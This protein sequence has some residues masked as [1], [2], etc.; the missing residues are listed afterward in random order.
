[1]ALMHFNAGAR[2]GYI[3]KQL[4]CCLIVGVLSQ[5]LL[6]DINVLAC[7]PEWAALATALGKETVNV[8]SA[9]TYQQ[10]P[11]HIQARPSLIAKARKADL[12][13]CSGAGLEE[14]WL[15]LLTRK[16]NNSKIQPG[17]I[18]HFVATEYV[19]LLGGSKKVDRSEGD[20][21]GLGNPHIHMNPNNILKVAKALSNTLSELEPERKSYFAENLS[22]F[23]KDIQKMQAKWK[24]Q[25]GALQGQQV[26]VH[27]DSWAYLFQWLGLEKVA[28][29]EPKPGLP[30]STSH[31]SKLLIQVKDKPTY[32]II[33]SSY[34][35]SK[36]AIWLGK[37]S[38]TP[39]I[40]LPYT[41]NNW[42]KDDALVSYYESLIKALLTVGE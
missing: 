4:L 21:H 5:P 30:P 18:G 37:R 19:R 15:P 3:M 29:L 35:S 9:T 36:P 39:V 2:E 38:H 1:M 26:I 17:A 34:Q 32:C 10:D 11:H 42:K 31:L 7:E 6:A 13:I 16:S 8:H 28:T 23:S 41:V 40:M 22:R 33:Y 20:V 14:G 12:L 24:D 25:I 27:H